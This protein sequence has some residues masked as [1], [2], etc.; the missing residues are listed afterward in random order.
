M[1]TQL[2]IVNVVT[3]AEEGVGVEEEVIIGEADEVMIDETLT[4][5][6]VGE[7]TEIL[8]VVVEEDL[9]G[10][11][12]DQGHHPDETLGIEAHTALEEDLTPIFPG[13]MIMAGEGM[14]DDDQQLLDHHRRYLY[15]HAQIRGLRHRAAE[16]HHLDL[17]HLHADIV[18]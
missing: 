8:V 14:Y 5:E 4:G 1:S 11:G 16:G 15:A 2:E 10:E 12:L 9:N 7:M 18:L 3:V 13:G 17:V 6:V